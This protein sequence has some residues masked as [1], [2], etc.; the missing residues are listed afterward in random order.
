MLVYPH[1]P[2]PVFLQYCFDLIYEIQADTKL[3]FF[4][5]GDDFFMMTGPY[6]GIESYGYL[7]PRI[8]PAVLP[9]L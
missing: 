3:R 5:A 1:E 9:E 2:E 7:A 6:T 4:T 8:E